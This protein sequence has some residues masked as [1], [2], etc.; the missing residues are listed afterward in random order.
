MRR[1]ADAGE[2]AGRA[3]RDRGGP[4][5]APARPRRARAGAAAE[6]RGDRAGGHAA[7]RVRA[8]AE[9]ASTWNGCRWSWSAGC[10][11]RLARAQGG[12]HL[13][14]LGRRGQ[15]HHLG[16]DRR[17]AWP[18]AARRSPCSRSTRQAAGEL[19]RPA[20]ARQR[21]AAREG[22]RGRRAL[23]DDARPQADLRRAGRVARARR[24]HA[25]R[26]ALEPHLPGALERRGGLSGVHGH[27][28]APR[29]PSGGPLR[30]AGARHASHAQR[31]RLPGRAKEAGRVH[32]L[33]HAPA[34]H[35]ARD[36]RAEGARTRLRRGAVRS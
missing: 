19:A 33:A 30:P 26:G 7:A 28:E 25:R 27:G 11:R 31:A 2:A 23:G 34:L 12:L 3:R 17:S 16:R 29:A 14:R 9:A 36:A 18:R 21:G 6:P 4:V 10:D 5:R 1:L 35:C 8:G 20:G 32:R 22:R 24:A 15:D 13:R